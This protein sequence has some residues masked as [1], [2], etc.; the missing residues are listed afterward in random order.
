MSDLLKKLAEQREALQVNKPASGE[1]VQAV[2]V[3]IEIDLPEGTL[4]C[5]LS[6]S[7]NILNS[8]QEFIGAIEE[9]GKAFKLAIY[10]KQSGGF[11]SRFSG[12]FN[13]GFNKQS[14]FRR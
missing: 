6:L 2:Q 9:I 14:Y 11:G 8:E 7:P 3:P 5:Y 10:R 13:G 4:R 12:G 1:T